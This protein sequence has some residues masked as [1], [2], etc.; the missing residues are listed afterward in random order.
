[1]EEAHSTATP[2]VS[3]CKLSNKRVTTH[4]STEAEDK[5]LAQT[6]T[7]LTCI[8]TLLTELQRGWNR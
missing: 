1:M 5:S 6:S 7:E 8:S 2:M 3:N 4:S